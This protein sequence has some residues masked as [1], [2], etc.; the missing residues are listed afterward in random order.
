MGGGRDGRTVTL[1]LTFSST[2]IYSFTHSLPHELTCSA[3]FNPSWPIALRR[4]NACMHE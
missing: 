3:F 1:P 4:L 2:E